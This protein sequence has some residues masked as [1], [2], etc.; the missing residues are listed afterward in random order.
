MA[1][2]IYEVFAKGVEATVWENE[3]KAHNKLGEEYIKKFLSVNLKQIYKVKGVSKRK[4]SF[5]FDS[6]PNIITALNKINEKFNVMVT[7]D[8]TELKDNL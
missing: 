7:T 4:E 6:I 2:V 1:K 5:D 8:N 3:A